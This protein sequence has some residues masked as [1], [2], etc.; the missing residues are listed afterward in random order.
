LLTIAIL[1]VPLVALL[2]F[3]IPILL[4]LLALSGLLLLAHV[5][6]LS[7]TVHVVALIFGAIPVFHCISFVIRTAICEMVSYSGVLLKIE[8][9]PANT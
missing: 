6:L 4:T 5:A 3:A 9:Q 1:L 2:A 8:Q 7:I